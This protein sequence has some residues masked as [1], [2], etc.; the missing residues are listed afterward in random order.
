MK[1]YISYILAVI[2]F[3]MIV[4]AVPFFIHV[5]VP[6]RLVSFMAFCMTYVAPVV[7]FT[8]IFIAREYENYIAMSLF[9]IWIA[10]F[11]FMLLSRV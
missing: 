10:G 6:F 9:V 1:K 7:L 3:L 11:I 8:L 2:S 4:S 5:N